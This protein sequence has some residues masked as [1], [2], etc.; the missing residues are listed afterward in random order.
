MVAHGEGHDGNGRRAPV[1]QRQLKATYEGHR[2]IVQRIG[3]L[4]GPVKLWQLKY[5]FQFHEK[6]YL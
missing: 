2:R 4:H 5:R 3:T 6:F 1:G